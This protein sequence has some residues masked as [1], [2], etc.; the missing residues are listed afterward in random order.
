[1]T[2]AK[3]ANHVDDSFEQEF[4]KSV[5]SNKRCFLRRAKV[6]GIKFWYLSQNLRLLL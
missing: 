1:M 2:G 3:M 4:Q 5:N 6:E